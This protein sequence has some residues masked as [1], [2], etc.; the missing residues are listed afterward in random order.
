MSASVAE[1][2]ACTFS[3]PVAARAGSATRATVTAKSGSTVGVTAESAQKR[4]K[5]AV[6]RVQLARAK[7]KAEALA[8]LKKKERK[9]NCSRFPCESEPLGKNVSPERDVGRKKKSQ[10]Y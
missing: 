5:G 2:H 8:F 7:H 4:R 3:R 10:R 6:R 1:I 9:K